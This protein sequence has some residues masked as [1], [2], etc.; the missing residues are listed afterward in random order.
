MTEFEQAIQAIEQKVSLI[1]SMEKDLEGLYES[2]S[3]MMEKFYLLKQLNRYES[4]IDE[5]SPELSN[6]IDACRILLEDCHE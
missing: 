4:R 2:L 6:R 1:D 5:F 3:Q